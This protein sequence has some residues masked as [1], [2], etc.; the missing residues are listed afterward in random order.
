MKTKKNSN[1]KS[2]K[3]LLIT[4]ILFV[5]VGISFATVYSNYRNNLSSNVKNLPAVDV[6]PLKSGQDENTTPNGEAS[7]KNKPGTGR[8]PTSDGSDKPSDGG[9]TQVNVTITSPTT[10]SISNFSVR[11]F[12]NRL[13]T[14][15][16]CT[17]TLTSSFGQTISKTAS[18]LQASNQVSACPEF[19]VSQD[20]LSKGVWTL[21]VTYESGATNGT[22]T[23]NVTVE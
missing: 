9:S 21:I 23:Q 12:I 8:T 18:G 6:S 11:S 5:V 13:T 10:Q 15:G 2:L 16:T 22:T 4:V 3:I 20:E 1:K 14:E 7:G 19:S 17:M